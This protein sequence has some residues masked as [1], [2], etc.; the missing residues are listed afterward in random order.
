MSEGGGLPPPFITNFINDTALLPSLE[1]DSDILVI[2]FPCMEYDTI[3]I[4]A[5]QLLILAWSKWLS[6]LAACHFLCLSGRNC[7]LIV[8][9]RLHSIT[10]CT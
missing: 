6:R 7:L 3:Y 10:G 5:R 2:T 4:N 8:S 1:A 9:F